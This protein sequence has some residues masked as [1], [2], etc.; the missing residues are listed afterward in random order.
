M[1]VLDPD[2]NKLIFLLF[3]LL[4][5]GFKAL[6]LRLVVVPDL[7]ALSLKPFVQLLDRV[8]FFL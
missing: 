6:N 8:V 4:Q 3:R 1:E 5:L 7:V 2:L